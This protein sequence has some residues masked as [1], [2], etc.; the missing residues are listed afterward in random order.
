MLAQAEA[1]RQNEQAGLPAAVGLKLPSPA[2]PAWTPRR[3]WAPSR[4][5]GRG[6]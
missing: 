4:R 3:T 5:T 2:R 6:C 1:L